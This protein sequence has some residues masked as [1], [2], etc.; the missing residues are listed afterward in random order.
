[1]SYQPSA[2]EGGEPSHSKAV[3]SQILC[4]EVT[5]LTCNDSDG[6]YGMSSWCT[7]RTEPKQFYDNTV[8]FFNIR[9]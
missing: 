3:E 4:D 1:M 8:P 5:Y 7:G 6:L 2:E 9:F